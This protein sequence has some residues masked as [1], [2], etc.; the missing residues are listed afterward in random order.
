MKNTNHDTITRT[1]GLRKWLRAGL[2]S[3]A[4]VL[5]G[6]ACMLL[7]MTASRSAWSQQKYAELSTARIHQ[8]AA[9]LPA[10]PSGFGV[11][12]ADRAAWAGRAAQ[13]QWA[14]PEAEAVLAKPLPPFD[15]Q[16]YLAYSR[17]GDRQPMERNLH[18]REDQ[19]I[20][21]VLAECVENNGRFLPRIN[22]VLNSLVDMPSW[23]LSAH[24]PQLLNFH[25]VRYYVELNSADMADNLAEALY[26]LGDKIPEATR[27][28]VAAEMEKHVFGPMRKSFETGKT[29]A[30]HNGNWW[31]YADMN[32]NA[33]CVK[34]V[35]GAALAMLPSVE[36]RAL[37]AAAAE[38]YIQH[39]DDGFNSDGYDTEGLGYWNYG[40]MHFI[41]LRENLFR[42]T[43]GKIDLLASPK[44]QKVALFGIEFPMMPGNAAAFGDAGTMP[45]ADPHL[46]M[47]IDHI[48]QI[49]ATVPASARQANVL[50]HVGL[51]STALDLFPVPGDTLPTPPE[52][53][54]HDLHTY[55][56]DSGV[57]VSHPAPG[58]DFAVTI[59]AGGNT[60]HSHND[61]G[62]FV[63]GL[64][65]VQPVGD[66]GGPHYYTGATFG[67]HRLDSK[68]LN[69]FG[70]PV[71][72]IGG[73]LQ[74][75]ATTVHVSVISHAFSNAQDSIT[76][77]MTNAYS[78]PALKRVTRT[79]VHNRAGNGIVEITDHFELAHPMEIIE[80]L[81]T[82]GT[83][84][85]V[86]ARTLL[87][88]L[89]GQQMRAV[90]DAPVPVTFTE[91][92][93]NDYGNA[94]TRV[95]VHVPLAGSGKVTMRFTPAK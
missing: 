75:D 37:F 72:E 44:M 52:L 27:K 78:V 67:P 7:G 38:H 62:S 41:E 69:S 16:A 83:W 47:V 43:H 82:H 76:I 29:G 56:A 30:D 68:L 91:S 71:P 66:P 45:K 48:F 94:F 79:M 77:D 36:D 54:H 95:E 31:L 8:I 32:W 39:Y 11:P 42:V 1:K 61:V 10:Q 2:P 34:G 14:I 51:T 28:H 50:Q 58:Q 60:T 9:M 59:K 86:D 57:L 46:L 70:H 13:L 22:E 3:S 85:K 73:Q 19:L 4:A 53:S 21:L 24:D 74:L 40:F 55:Y 84:Q 89:G 81:P 87:F 64:E 17:T 33:V 80:S 12:C 49:P 88:E 18:S 26:L 23:T 35:T 6:L 92:K 65:N 25:G 93:V 20:P 15:P 5:T 90:I 63:I